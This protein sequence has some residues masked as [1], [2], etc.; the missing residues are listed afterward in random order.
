VSYL[1]L[2]FETAQAAYDAQLPEYYDQEDTE[3]Y[4]ISLRGMAVV[5]QDVLANARDIFQ[6]KACPTCL[7]AGD[8]T[9]HCY[10][11]DRVTDN[12]VRLVRVHAGNDV[13]FAAYGTPCEACGTEFFDTD[14]EDTVCIECKAQAA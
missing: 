13:Y 5:L 3:R 4:E 11:Y 8:S 14:L 6:D 1:G 9:D 10:V 12:H 2:G 7:L